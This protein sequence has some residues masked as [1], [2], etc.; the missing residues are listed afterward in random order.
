MKTI[1][2]M[3]GFGFWMVLVIVHD[4][5]DYYW[6]RSRVLER[7]NMAGAGCP[8][9]RTGPRSGLRHGAGADFL[10]YGR[11]RRVRPGGTRSLQDWYIRYQ[12]NAVEGVSGWP[13]SAATSSNTR[14]TWT[15]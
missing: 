10:V 15:R 9:R 8:G 1:R 7:M 2:S 11:G 5:I 3:S 14:S 12:L 6:A 13:P 4:N